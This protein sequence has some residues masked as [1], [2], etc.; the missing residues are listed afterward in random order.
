MDKNFNKIGTKKNIFPIMNPPKRS[1]E[2]GIPEQDE[3]TSSPSK[4]SIA[5]IE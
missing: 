5:D 2:H 4:K 3:S 1:S